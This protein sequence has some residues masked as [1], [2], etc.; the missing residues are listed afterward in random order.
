M[1]LSRDLILVNPEKVKLRLGLPLKVILPRKTKKDK[2]FHLNKNVERNAHYTDYNKAKEIFT[3]ALCNELADCGVV[4]EKPV[5]FLFTLY[6]KGK[7]VCDVG[8]YSIVEKFASDAIVKAGIIKDDN[9]KFVDGIFWCW[10][11]FA[12]KDNCVLEIIEL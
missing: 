5:C 10:G 12:D 9:Y 7:A 1:G 2:V 6:K 3:E 4:I 8:N 11:G